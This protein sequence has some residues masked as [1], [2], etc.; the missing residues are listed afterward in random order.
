MGMGFSLSQESKNI[1]KFEWRQIINQLL[2]S[3]E[4]YRIQ[5][6][7]FIRL[8]VIIALNKE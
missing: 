7:F 4:Q 1:L 6:I 3:I 8:Y 2:L 5:M